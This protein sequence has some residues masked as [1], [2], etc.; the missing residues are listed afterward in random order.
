MEQVLTFAK[1]TKLDV[2]KLDKTEIQYLDNLVQCNSDKDYIIA[3]YYRLTKNKLQRKYYIRAVMNG[4][5]LASLKIGIYYYNVK[6]YNMAYA[7]WYKG[8]KNGDFFAAI[9]KINLM[10]KKKQINLNDKFKCDYLN[11]SHFSYFENVCGFMKKDEDKQTYYNKNKNTVMGHMNNRSYLWFLY[12]SVIKKYNC[13]KALIRLAEEYKEGQYFVGSTRLACIYIDGKINKNHD[14]LI[15]DMNDNDKAKK[16]SKRIV[17]KS[18]P[19]VVEKQKPQIESSKNINLVNVDKNLNKIATN[20]NIPGP[21]IPI[22]F[23]IDNKKIDASKTEKFFKKYGSNAYEL[24][25]KYSIENNKYDMDK[26]IMVALCKH[27]KDY[28]DHYLSNVSKE[29]AEEM[30]KLI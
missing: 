4:A 11:K 9:N 27:D 6:N 16:F 20:Y 18:K 29:K 22:A 13:E 1:F 8:E 3:E 26:Y 19:K 15:L 10:N 23:F 28:L 2:E 14:D 12:E 21:T 5:P 17:K 25:I 24:L 30:Y 7:H